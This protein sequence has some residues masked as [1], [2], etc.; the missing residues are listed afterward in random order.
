MRITDTSDLWWKTA[1]VYCLDVEKFLD[2]DG[3]GVGDFAGLARRMDYLH[4]LGITCLWLMPFYPTPNRDDGYDISDFFGVDPR[5]GDFGDFVEMIRLAEDRGIRVIVDLVVNHTSDQ[6]QWF[7]AARRSR[8]SRFRDFYVWQDEIPDD[9]PQGVVFP[10]D[11]TG[12]WT[13]DPEAGQYYLHR[14][15]HHQPDLNVANAEVRDEIAKVIGFW[16][17][18][19][20]SG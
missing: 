7:Q 16:L 5:L 9:G 19:G 10:G 6:H 20:L 4:E 8:Q 15:Y 17:A 2:G 11:Q 18:Q 1:V 3:D 14:F 13:F 12:V